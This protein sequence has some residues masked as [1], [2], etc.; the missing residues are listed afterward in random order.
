L[1]HI[2]ES[3]AWLQF[4][5]E[6]SNIAISCSFCNSAKNEKFLR[7]SARIRKGGGAK[8]TACALAAPLAAGAPYPRAPNDYRYVHPHV[9]EYSQHIKIR[10]GW[11]YIPKSRK[12]QRTVRSLKL[13]KV[14]E[15]EMKLREERLR[16]RVGILS[17]VAAAIAEFD[18]ASALQLGSELAT[19]LSRKILRMP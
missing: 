14:A 1:E 7:I 9:D 15:I 16:S 8:Y 10:K 5:Y 13:N 18:R 17:T 11:L 4:A 12:G 2:L 19:E 3:S 6:V